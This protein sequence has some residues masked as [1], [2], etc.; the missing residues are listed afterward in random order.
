MFKHDYRSKREYEFMLKL[1]KD[2]KVEMSQGHMEEGNCRDIIKVARQG[3][4]YMN[5]RGKFWANTK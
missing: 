3:I 1:E 4:K 2:L 5:D